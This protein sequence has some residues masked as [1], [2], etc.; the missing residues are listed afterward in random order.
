MM[1]RYF[2]CGFISPSIMEQLF[3]GAPRCPS[4]AKIRGRP[5]QS[6][7]LAIARH[8]LSANF[9]N[10]IACDRVPLWKQRISNFSFGLWI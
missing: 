5:Q 1:L 8:R 4:G 7:C 6:E 10:S 9:P 2:R 3:A